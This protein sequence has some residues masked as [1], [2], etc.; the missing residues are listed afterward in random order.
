[1]S[2][3]DGTW[4][5]LFLIFVS[6]T[7][8]RKIPGYFCFCILS[9]LGL[10]RRRSGLLGGR[11]W[12]G[13][14]LER[15]A[16]GPGSGRVEGAGCPDVI[17]LRVPQGGTR[18]R[19]RGQRT[20]AG[21]WGSETG[22]GGGGSGSGR[23]RPGGGGIGGL[24]PPSPLLGSSP[25]SLSVSADARPGGSERAGPRA[26]YLPLGPPRA[27]VTLTALSLSLP[28]LHP[29]YPRPIPSPPAAAAKR[30][31]AHIHTL[32]LSTNEKTG[33]GRCELIS[34]LYE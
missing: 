10:L 30:F 7:Q 18:A 2:R 33:P 9:P 21:L 19:L 31:C 14:E 27:V 3:C 17:K 5:F 32:T 4:P 12:G 15:S 26:Q 1:M 20:G 11:G 16:P 29:S 8:S 6:R 28:P 24:I 13:P 22:G 34:S 25:S 23:A